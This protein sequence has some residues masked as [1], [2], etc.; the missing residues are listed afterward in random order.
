MVM[1]VV[2]ELVSRRYR[3][4]GPVMTQAAALVQA[5]RTRPLDLAVVNIDLRE[6]RGAGVTLARTVWTGFTIASLLVGGDSGV[7]HANRDA[8][9]GHLME[10][11][12]PEEVVQSIEAARNV[13]LGHPAPS[14]LPRGLTL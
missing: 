7:A 12:S 6:G 13:L 5:A 8:A 11:C 14:P 4:H 10:P 1:A 3:V 9:V 2:S